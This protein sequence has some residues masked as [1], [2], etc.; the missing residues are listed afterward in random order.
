[1]T[2]HTYVQSKIGG[3]QWVGDT[4]VYMNRNNQNVNYQGIGEASVHK[5]NKENKKSKTLFF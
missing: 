1:M 5:R 4:T 3:Y 2:D